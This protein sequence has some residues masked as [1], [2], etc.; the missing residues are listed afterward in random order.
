MGL[1]SGLLWATCNV[2]AATPEEYGGYYCWGG[3]T[4]K[5]DTDYYPQSYGDLYISYDTARKK[6]GGNWKMPSRIQCQE[7]IGGTTWKWTTLKGVSGHLCTS[8]TN[9]QS[10]FFPAAGYYSNSRIFYPGTEGCYWTIS[11]SENSNPHYL[12]VTSAKFIVGQQSKIT[13]CSVRAVL[14]PTTL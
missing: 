3:S 7:L 13:P 6:M 9:G 11:R 14:D 1:P 4:N 10:I 12:H 2:G 8:N 5:S